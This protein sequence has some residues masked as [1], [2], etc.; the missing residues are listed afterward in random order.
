MGNALQPHLI[1]SLQ[2]RAAAGKPV[3]TGLHPRGGS[4]IF[5]VQIRS[6]SKKG[7]ARRGSNCGPNVKKPTSWHKRGGSGPPGPPPPSGS[8][9]AS[10][11]CPGPP[12][13]FRRWCTDVGIQAFSSNVGL[14]EA[15]IHM[16]YQSI[17]GWRKL[18]HQFHSIGKQLLS[19]V[20]YFD[21]WGRGIVDG[22]IK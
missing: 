11:V 1:S 4:R 17:P 14:V 19:E 7:G 9:T 22:A 20:I 10:I 18:F 8:A 2:A 16:L 21:M 3:Q 15:P 13:A 12:K 6:T 5:V